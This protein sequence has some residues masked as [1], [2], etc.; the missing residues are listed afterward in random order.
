MSKTSSASGAIG[1]LLAMAATLFAVYYDL[2][3]SIIALLH[4]IRTLERSLLVLAAFAAFLFIFWFVD[5]LRHPRKPADPK[6]KLEH[7]AVV[8]LPTMRRKT[9]AEL[10]E[11]L[12][13]RDRTK[14]T[15][16]AFEA[17]G[18]ALKERD[19]PSLVEGVAEFRNSNSF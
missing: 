15:E 12:T 14:W 1:I 17:A 13:D 10:L 9:T 11:I 18:R 19:V 4:P 8:I 5:R 2:K 3:L 16:A 6:A 7:G